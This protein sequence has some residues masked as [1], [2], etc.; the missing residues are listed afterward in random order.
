MGR[1]GPY[2]DVEKYKQCQIITKSSKCSLRSPQPARA[3]SPPCRSVIGLD[4]VV[5]LLQ[6]VSPT[7][8]ISWQLHRD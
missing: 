8:V 5:G 2:L 4:F 7:I 1:M 3:R 6:I